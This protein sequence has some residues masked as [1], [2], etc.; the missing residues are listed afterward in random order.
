MASR[1]WLPAAVGLA[2]SGVLL[3]W[4][5]K[6]VAWH[7]VRRYISTAHLSWL[8]ASVVVAT[9]TF[10]LRVVRWRLLLRASDGTS[11][12]VVPLWHATAIGFMGNNVLPFRAGE[13]MRSYAATRLTGA[14]FAAALSS[15]AVERAF[16]GLAVVALLVLGL[17]TAGL[18]SDVAVGDV[19]ISRIATGAGIVMVAAL[20]AGLAVVLAPR[21]AER[22][23][24]TIVPSDT[25]ATR[26][27]AIVEGVRH[28]LS[29]LRSP[30]RVLYVAGWSLVLWLVNAVSFWLMFQAFE[31][32]VNFAA[33]LVLQGVLVFGIAVPST[34]GYVGVFEFAIKSVLLLFA[35]DPDRAIAYAV[36]YHVTT[37][38]PIVVLGAWS[39]LHT[40]L[41]LR[42]LRSAPA[43]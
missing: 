30:L 19:P 15:V 33:A 43:A 40:S 22:A 24:R 39:L 3:Y 9:L 16:D 27:V 25:V 18:P 14:R 11:L 36:T 21:L 13:L 34:P 2:I 6:D 37:F 4:A 26:L 38:M 20:L 28:G 17:F 5:L 10:L 23:I 7:E 32:P 42:E 41:S 31:L 35:I 1:R 29:A 12:P 8:L